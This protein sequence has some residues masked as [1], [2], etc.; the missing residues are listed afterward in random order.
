MD[1]SAQRWGIHFPAGRDPASADLLGRTS[2]PAAWTETWRRAPGAPALLTAER[3]VTTAEELESETRSRAQSMASLGVGPGDRVLLHLSAR[4]DLVVNHLAALRLGATVVP[5]NPDYSVS[6]LDRVVTDSQPRLVLLDRPAKLPGPG[7]GHD[8]GPMVR[9]PAD[10]W[11]R[12]R[13]VPLDSALPSDPALLVYTSGTTGRPK[14]T[15]LSHGN[16][17][18]GVESV[19]LAWRWTSEDRL[20][21]ALPLFHVHGLGIGLHGTL[22]A[23]ASAVLLP[24]FAP[25]AVAD[26]AVA[27]RATMFFGVPTMYRRIVGS[28][29]GADLR[30]LRLCVSGSAPLPAALFHAVEQAC[31]QTVLERYGMTETLMLLSNPYDGERRPGS[32][33]VELPGVEVR[34]AEQGEGEILVRGPN[35]FAGYWRNEAATATAFDEDGFFRTGDVGRRDPDGYLRIV[36]RLKDL[37]ISGGLNVYPAEVEDVLHGCPGV[38]EAAIVGSPSEEWGEVVTA[39]VVRDDERLTEAAISEHVADRLAPYK[40]PR[41]VRFVESLPRNQLGK[42]LRGELVGA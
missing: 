22:A 26:A 15:R 34:L 28:G 37:I 14:G 13:D 6:E 7:T 5:T 24:R 8:G 31:G 32:V 27:D 39:F 17:L 35:V 36:G 20:V 19:R 41:I 16:L 10:R 4:L 42:V 18:A 29:R 21:L 38:R 3:G 12:G 30:R 40:R 2:L 33:G 11:P 9:G 1:G 23:G 25:D